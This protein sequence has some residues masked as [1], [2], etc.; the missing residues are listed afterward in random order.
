MSGGVYGG[1]EVGA[2]VF[3]FGAHTCRAGFAGE[4]TPKA[5]VLT[6]MGVSSSNNAMET[7]QPNTNKKYY[8]DTNSV[9]VARENMDIT[10]LIKDSMI[11]EWDLFEKMMDHLYERHIK[12]ESELHPVL[13]SEAS[14]NTKAKREKLTEVMFEKYKVP[15]YFLCKNAVL[16][17]F[18]NG[19][20]TA[21]VIDSGS[22]QTS[23]VPVVDGYVLQQAMIRTPLAGDLITVNCKSYFDE[24]GVEIIPPYMIASKDVVKERASPVY[25]KK[26]VPAVSQSYHDLMVRRVLQDFA[27]SVAQVS[28]TSLANEIQNSTSIPPSTYVFPNGYNLGLTVDRFKLTEALFDASSHNLK[29]IHGG[30]LLSIPNVVTTS[31]GMCDIDIR[32]SLYSGIIAVGGNSLIPGFTERLTKELTIKTPPSIRVKVIQNVST[33]EKRFSSWIG[34]SILASLGTFQQLWI[35]KVEYDE[36]G[37]TVVEKKCP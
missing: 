24:L 16:S 7:E 3:D 36:M 14:W 15:A 35:S 12:S 31:A 19:R 5:D 37:K 27:A 2:L 22:T 18:A 28:D 4:D 13:F 21:L 10:T 30:D 20:S 23:C 8:I 26:K 33:V 34:G 32:P 9:C 25:T 17:A 6:V 1:D 29:G 11:E